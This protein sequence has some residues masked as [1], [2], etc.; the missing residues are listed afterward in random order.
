MWDVKG[1]STGLRGVV[2]EAQQ[3]GTFLEYMH[4]LADDSKVR[5][6]DD[7]PVRLVRRFR[8]ENEIAW[9]NHQAFDRRVAVNYTNNDFARSCRGLAADKKTADIREADFRFANRRIILLLTVSTTFPNCATW[10]AVGSAGVFWRVTADN[11]GTAFDVAHRS[12]ASPPA[13]GATAGASPA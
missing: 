1:D 5:L 12:S 9:S 7:L 3:I 13:N 8:L 11:R 10:H 2:G 6:N 4:Y